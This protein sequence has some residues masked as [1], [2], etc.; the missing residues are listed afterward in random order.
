MT[1]DKVAAISRKNMGLLSGQRVLP[2][3]VPPVKALR[4]LRPTPHRSSLQLRSADLLRITQTAHA[5]I[6]AAEYPCAGAPE[7][8]GLV[9]NCRYA[10]SELSRTESSAVHDRLSRGGFD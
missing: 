3:G 4:E 5:P 7:Q 8:T 10:T 9:P 1:R 6:R 2:T